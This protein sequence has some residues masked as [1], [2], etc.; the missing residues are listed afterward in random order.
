MAG[1]DFFQTRMGH[2]FYESTAPRI[3]KALERIADALEKQNAARKEANDQEHE[4]VGV[5]VPPRGQTEDG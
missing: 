3:A 4:A 2:H 5:Q 1:P